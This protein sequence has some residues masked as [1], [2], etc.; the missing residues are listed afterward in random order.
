MKIM[1]QADRLRVK[2]PDK[3]QRALIKAYH[4]LLQIEENGD[5]LL[6][7]GEPSRLY[8]LLFALAAKYDVDLI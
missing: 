5:D 8:H 2:E 1:I 7:I 6:I 4:A 3:A